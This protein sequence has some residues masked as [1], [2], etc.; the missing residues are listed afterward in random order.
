MLFRSSDLSNIA[1]FVI[2]FKSRIYLDSIG[3]SY[4]L[5]DYVRVRVINE[6]IIKYVVFRGNSMD[7]VSIHRCYYV[8]LYIIYFFFQNNSFFLF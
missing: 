8:L 2:K 7:F 4:L 5:D 6:I 3:S 1:C